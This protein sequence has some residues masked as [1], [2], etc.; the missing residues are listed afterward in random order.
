MLE[1]IPSVLLEASVVCTGTGGV[2]ST[3]MVLKSLLSGG[4]TSG[5]GDKEHSVILAH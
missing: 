5:S 1:W 3:T 4:G 2:L